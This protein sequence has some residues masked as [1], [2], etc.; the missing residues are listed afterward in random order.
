[1]TIEEVRELILP[2]L[3]TIYDVTVDGGTTHRGLIEGPYKGY[4]ESK[5]ENRRN[6]YIF[7]NP[8]SS[9]LLDAILIKCSVIN[10]IEI[11]N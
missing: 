11:A 3:A 6:D 5:L 9:G 1:M 10:R 4:S 7:M 8:L 2:D